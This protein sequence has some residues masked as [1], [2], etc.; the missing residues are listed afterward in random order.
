M[1]L[2]YTFVLD[3]FKPPDLHSW[4]LNRSKSQHWSGI[5]KSLATQWHNDIILLPYGL[6]PLAPPLPIAWDCIKSAGIDRPLHKPPN[7]NKHGSN[8]NFRKFRRKF[9]SKNGIFENSVIFIENVRRFF[10]R[11][12]SLG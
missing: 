8:E 9:R 11:G 12:K 6:T 7:H 2:Y 3:T 4:P 1:R 10:E 5:S